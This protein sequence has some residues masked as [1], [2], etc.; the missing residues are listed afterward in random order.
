MFYVDILWVP[1]QHKQRDGAYPYA[2][3]EA[4]ETSCVVIGFIKEVAVC[5]GQE[6]I[7]R[8]G[9]GCFASNDLNTNGM[10]AIRQVA[11]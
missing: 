1:P 10:S 4:S 8:D 9:K 5:L 7:T 6:T 3:L 11:A 2:P